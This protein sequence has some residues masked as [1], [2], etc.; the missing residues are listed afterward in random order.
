MRSGPNNLKRHKVRMRVRPDHRLSLCFKKSVDYNGLKLARSPSAQTSSFATNDRRSGIDRCAGPI[1]ENNFTAV[2]NPLWI[3]G[4]M[5]GAQSS[6]G[7]GVFSAL[8]CPVTGDTRQNR[9]PARETRG[10]QR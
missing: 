7:T 5:S 4:A 9:L 10:G 3:D 1:R 2:R 6:A 8:A